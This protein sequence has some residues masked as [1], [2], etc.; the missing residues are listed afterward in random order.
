MIREWIASRLGGRARQLWMR[1]ALRGVGQADNHSRLDLAYLVP[2]PWRLDSEAEHARYRA[3]SAAVERAFGRPRTILEVGC[4]EGVQSEYFAKQCDRLTGI[5]V[6]PRAIARA[7][8]RLPD[9]E[10]IAGDLLA[11]P[12]ANEAGRFDVVVACEVIYYMSDVPRFLAAMNR[13]GRGC[14]VTYF[15]AAERKMGQY[16]RAIPGVTIERIAHGDAAWFVA[17]WTPPPAR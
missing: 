4:G 16:V 3:T 17:T 11:Q 2:D 5:D 8:K 9:A 10:L 15:A 7:K 1:F 6:S 13:L 12:W 14:V